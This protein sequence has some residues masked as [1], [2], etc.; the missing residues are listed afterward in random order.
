MT[1]ELAAL[2]TRVQDATTVYC[3]YY[4]STINTSCVSTCAA[5]RLHQTIDATKLGTLV[6]VLTDCWLTALT[7]CVDCVDWVLTDCWLTALT[8][9]VDWLRWLTVDWLGWLCWLTVLTDC[10]LAVDWLRWM[11]VLIDCVDWLLTDCVDCVDG[12]CV[13]RNPKRVIDNDYDESVLYLFYELLPLVVPAECPFCLFKVSVQCL[14]RN[15]TRTVTVHYAPSWPT[16]WPTGL[17]IAM[18]DIFVRPDG[19]C[20]SCSTLTNCI[21]VATQNAELFWVVCCLCFIRVATLDDD[22]GRPGTLH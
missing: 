1:L 8:D 11:L 17:L 21:V 5:T 18:H 10:W 2:S 16:S 14:E 6:M 7:G 3:W 20:S 12:G 13:S 22:T 9:C 15:Y 4:V 19:W